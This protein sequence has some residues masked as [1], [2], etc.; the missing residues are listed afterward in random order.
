MRRFTASI[1]ILLASNLCMSGEAFAD[2][3]KIG[4]VLA[5][6]G[7]APYIGDPQA[8]TLALL[9]DQVNAAGGLRGRKIEIIILDSQGDPAKGAACVRTLIDRHVAAVI[10]P[11]TSAESLAVMQLCEQ[12]RTVMISLGADRRLVDPVRKYVFKIPGPLESFTDAVFGELAKRHL[13]SIALLTDAWFGAGQ[14]ELLL[15]ACADHGI[16]VAFRERYSQLDS[17]FT[18]LAAR[19]KEKKFDAIVNWANGPVQGTITRDLRRAGLEEPLFQSSAFGDPLFVQSAGPAAEGVFFPQDPVITGQVEPEAEPQ[20]E[21]LGRYRSAYE[22]K[23]GS[24]PGFFG[25]LAADAFAVLARAI[26]DEGTEPESVRRGL[27][28][29]KGLPGVNGVFNFSPTDHNG[30]APRIA[31]LT[32]RDGSFEPTNRMTAEKMVEK[33]LFD[34]EENYKPVVAVMDF[35]IEK[36]PP[37]DGDL[38]QDVLGSSLVRSKRYYVVEKKQR[39]ALLQ[40]MQDSLTDLTDEAAQVRVGKWLGAKKIFI[41]SLG[42]VEGKILVTVKLIDLESSV[43]EASQSKMFASIAEI[44]DQSDALIDALSR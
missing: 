17:D 11:S 30:I 6:T 42:Q 12:S 7:G 19:L 43:T 33:G 24:S 22:K 3:I 18:A 34:P 41:G 44:L 2:T 37:G 38:I 31:L 26:A 21:A 32:V 20:L 14:E 4:A 10:G 13:T 23:Y 28:G 25:G 27:E 9:A 16:A 36:L 1:L 35:T 5:V 8:K 15:K 29:L 39:Q 40:T